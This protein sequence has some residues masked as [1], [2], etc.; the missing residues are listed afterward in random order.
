M[1]VRNKNPSRL[2][3]HDSDDN[4]VGLINDVNN[5]CLKST[6]NEALVSQITVSRK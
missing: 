1:S 6:Y 2:V 4:E 5:T 3:Y